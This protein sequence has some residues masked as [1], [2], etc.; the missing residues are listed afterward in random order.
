MLGVEGFWRPDVWPSLFTVDTRS[1]YLTVTVYVFMGVYA[2]LMVVPVVQLVRIRLRAPNI[3]WTTQKIFFVLLWLLTSLRCTFFALTPHIDGTFFNVDIKHPV[4][5]VLSD[6]P[7]VVFFSTYTLL[8]LFWSEIIS[9]AR[10]QS[11]MD[12]RQ[13]RSVY[14]TV[15]LVVYLLQLIIWLLLVFLSDYKNYLDLF[16]NIYH[17]V[18]TFIVA[19]IPCCGWT[20]LSYDAQ[21]SSRFWRAAG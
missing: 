19:C 16:D 5:A 4:F 8:I 15:N 11:H 18:T 9:H 14:L 10:N 6:L 2:I 12:K 20:S 17:S 21:I 3:G 13:L 7:G 1:S